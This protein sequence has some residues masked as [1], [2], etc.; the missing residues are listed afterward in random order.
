MKIPQKTNENHFIHEVRQE[1]EED[2]DED[3]EGSRSI[4]SL[5]H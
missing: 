5:M 3:E 2:E 4:H 1:F